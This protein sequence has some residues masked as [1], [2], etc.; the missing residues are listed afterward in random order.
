MTAELLTE[1]TAIFPEEDQK[2]K[3]ETVLQN[4]PHDTDL[5]KLTNYCMSVLFG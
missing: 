3:L 5:T 4:H 2:D 1:L